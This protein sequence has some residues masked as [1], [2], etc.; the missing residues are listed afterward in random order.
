MRRIVLVRHAKAE[1]N[2]MNDHERP[3]SE[4]GRLEAPETG[5]WLAGAGVA[6]GLA[7]VSTARRARQT[8]ESIVPEL[9]AAPPTVFEDRVYEADAADLLA[10]VGETSEAV[11]VLL[12]LGHNPGVHEAADALAGE[13]DGDLLDRMDGSEFPNG[14]M[15]VLEF[16]GPWKG[17]EPGVA[18]LVAFWAPGA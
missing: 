14:S 1:P 12:V 11:S 7:L 2:G 5:R 16:G 8:W 13:A 18:R 3:L 15:A 17:V 6:P 10:L 9:P 4:A